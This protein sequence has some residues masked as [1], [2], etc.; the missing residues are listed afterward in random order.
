MPNIKSAQKR[1]RQDEKKHYRNLQRKKDMR[2][3]LKEV[4]VLVSE[5]KQ[6][7]ALETLPKMYKAI[8]KAVK[9]NAAARKKSGITKIVNSKKLT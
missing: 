3:L 1:L 9:N 2:G 8:N 7:E 6:K 5:K 4:K